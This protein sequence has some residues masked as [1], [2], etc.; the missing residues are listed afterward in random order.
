[1][2]LLDTWLLCAGWTWPGA[3]TAVVVVLEGCVVISPPL[4]Y[5]K[6]MEIGT[7][8]DQKRHLQEVTITLWI[9]CKW[10]PEAGPLIRSEET[11]RVMRIL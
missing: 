9:V 5:G 2:R 11:R 6:Q 7:H 4:I 10:F 3:R 8:H 1:M